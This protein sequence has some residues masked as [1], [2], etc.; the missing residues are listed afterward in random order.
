[1]KKG[2]FTQNYTYGGK[3]AIKRVGSRFISLPST[4]CPIPDFIPL[5]SFVKDAQDAISDED[6]S[7]IINLPSVESLETVNFLT[8]CFKTLEGGISA[9]VNALK[10]SA[11]KII[12]EEYAEQLVEAWEYADSAINFIDYFNVGGP[13]FMLGTIHQ[14]WLTRPFVAFP[15]ELTDEEKSYYRPFLFQAQGEDNANDLLDLQGSRWLAGYS[16]TRLMRL[17]F[18]RAKKD[19]YKAMRIIGRLIGMV[20][21]K[22]GIEYLD[23]FRSRLEMFNCLMTN[24]ENAINFQNIIDTTDYNKEPKD[25]TEVS[26]EQGDV[27]LHNLNNI[28]RREIDNTLKI[29]SLIKKHPGK[30]IITSDLEEGETIMQFGPEIL[31]DLERKIE[32]MENHRH[33]FSRLYKSYN[34]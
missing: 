22:E 34:K 23:L 31:K 16:G 13:L 17:T 11:S 26:G 25:E 30:L 3:D 27:R 5:F 12:G 4:A 32:I 21:S 28:V 14:R 10:V 19:S 9:R 1:L 33:D 7:V 15:N 6:S 18:T 24:A 29:I 2:Q 8:K 20:E